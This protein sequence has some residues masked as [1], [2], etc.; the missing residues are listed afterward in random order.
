MN[1]P[2]TLKDINIFVDGLGHLGTSKEIKLPVIKQKKQALTAGGFE[3]EFD[4]GTFE[5][6][7]AEFTLAEY[8]P[9]VFAAMV[10]GEATGLGVNIT[11]KAS[12]IQGGKK[13]QALATLQGT[14][15][16]DD[17]TWK[18]NQEVERKV[19]MNVNKY[20]LEIGGKQ[21]LLFDTRNMIA[22]IDG[23]DYLETLRKH[24][25]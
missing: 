1:Y 23:V 5:K 10:A 19:K 16:V 14:V 7:E 3:Q 6:L 15:E 9:I 13:I 11:V 22:I 17:G 4:T 18:A 25:Q 2:Q 21:G 20:I 8:S 24:I 12:I